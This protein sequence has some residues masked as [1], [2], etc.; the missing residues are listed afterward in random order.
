MRALLV[1]LVAAAV[2]AI[3]VLFA[4]DPRPPDPLDA[5]PPPRPIDEILQYLDEQTVVN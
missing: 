2:F 3:G 4:D 1:P 5:S